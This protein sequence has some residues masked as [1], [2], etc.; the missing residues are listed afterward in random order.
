MCSSETWFNPAKKRATNI[1]DCSTEVKE[2]Q[3]IGVGTVLKGKK[4]GVT[5]II[6]VVVNHR[7]EI[8]H[9]VWNSS[10]VV[11]TGFSGPG[12]PGRTLYSRTTHTLSSHGDFY[13]RI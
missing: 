11:R 2:L 10:D 3:R 4:I 9:H 5:N 12:L 13:I 8:H 1:E 7:K 6:Y